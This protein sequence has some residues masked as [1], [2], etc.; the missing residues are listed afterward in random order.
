VSAVPEPAAGAGGLRCIVAVRCT[1]DERADWDAQAAAA[2]VGRSD[3]I[4]ARMAGAGAATATGRRR[5]PAGP[6]ADP[7]D[8]ALLRAVARIGNNVNQLARW[9]NTERGLDRS[10]LAEL[11]AVEEQLRGL[12]AAVQRPGRG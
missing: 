11:A 7:V 10:V 1:A 5:R 6:A 9:A 8:P 3:L 2:G 4:R 12:V